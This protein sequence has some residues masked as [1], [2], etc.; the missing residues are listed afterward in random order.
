MYHCTPSE[1][2]QQTG[3]DLLEMLRDL[4]CLAMEVRVQEAKR[5]LK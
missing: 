1:L 2:K 3:Q 4:E 5:K